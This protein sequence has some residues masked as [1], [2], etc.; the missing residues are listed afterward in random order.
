MNSA[1]NSTGHSRENGRSRESKDASI[2][3]ALKKYNEHLQEQRAAQ[4][5]ILTRK[6][7]EMGPQEAAKVMNEHCQYCE[8]LLVPK[9]ITGMGNRLMMIWP[10]CNC[11]QSKAS[12]AQI[13]EDKKQSHLDAQMKLY[14]ARLDKSGLIGWMR[15]ATFESYEPRQEFP[16]GEQCRLSVMDYSQRFLS[17]DL[18]R[19]AYHVPSGEMDLNKAI[20]DYNFHTKTEIN[21]NWLVLYGNFGN[22]KSH[23]AAAIV[24]AAI[25]A[26][27]QHV[28]FRVWPEYLDKLK[29]TFDKDY[30]GDQAQAQILAELRDGDLVVIDDLDKDQPTEWVRTILY[31]ALNHRYNEGLPTVLTFNFAPTDRSPKNAGR[32]ALEDYLGRAVIDRVIEV[33]TMVKFEGPSYRSGLNWSV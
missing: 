22:G 8:A 14:Q 11:D 27:R 25:D 4:V 1:S 3:R 19:R 13:A 2:G 15:S 24:K 6:L 16:T 21:K 10:D 12:A 18:D 7:Y 20:Q 31:K 9:F 26:G 29:A 30:D 32:L 5:R 23:L 28:Y 33:S 17:G